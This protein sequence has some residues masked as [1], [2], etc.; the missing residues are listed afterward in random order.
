[1]KKL[2]IVL[3]CVALSIGAFAQNASIHK[4][5]SKKV[6]SKS[7]ISPRVAGHQELVSQPVGGGNRTVLLSE[8]FQGVTLGNAPAAIPTGWTTVA[9]GT[10]TA[11]QTTPAFKIY[12]S[13]LA[14]AGGYWPVPQVGT[15]N[16]FAGANDDPA[17]CDCDFLDVWLQTPSMTL[18]DYEYTSNPVDVYGIITNTAVTDTWTDPQDL[19]SGDVLTATM[20]DPNGTVVW[21]QI[22]INFTVAPAGL[23]VMVNVNGYDFPVTASGSVD[24]SAFG[25]GGDLVWTI[26]A[27]NGEIMSGVTVD[28]TG[29]YE[30]GEIITDTIPAN[31]GDPGAEVV[32]VV[33][34]LDST[35]VGNY[36]LGF[37]FFH[38]ANFGGGD[39]TVQISTDGGAT[40]SVLDTLT[41]DEAYWQSL[42]LPLY[43]YNGMDISIRFQWSD[44]SAWA[45]GFAV[46]NV[47]VQTAL[48]NDIS[49][50]KTIASDW[51]NAT[52]G[53]GFWEYSNVPITQVSPIKATSVVYNAGFNNQLGVGVNYDIDFNG[54]AQGSFASSVLDVV[55]LDKDTLSGVSAFTPSALGTV[56]ITGT[57]AAADLV[58][59]NAN[60]NVSTASIEITQDIYARDLGAAQ[61][62][63]GPTAAYEYGNLFDIYAND[64]FGAIDVCVRL[65]SGV[66]NTTIQGR[67]YE[68]QGLDATTGEPVL[69]DLG[70][71]TQ[72]YTVTD[73]D[74]TSAGGGVWIHLLFDAP[75]TL[76]ADK[77]YFASMVSDGSV[78][79]PVSG[80]NDWVVSWLND[81]TWGATGGI[82]M[83]RLN[84]D[85]T[86]ANSISENK[87]SD[88]TMSQ[89]M[90]NPANAET[91]I[92]Y[93]LPTASPVSVI[94]RD[95]TGRVV[96]NM[97]E[98]V[99]PAGAHSIRINVAE[100]GSGIYTYTLNAGEVH[101]TKEMLVK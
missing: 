8:D 99:K 67:L 20:V 34:V 10:A 45:S 15:N 26:T 50:A 31:Q 88:V 61:A 81:G 55:T 3:G 78:G 94:V 63:V 22:S 9:A 37:D 36:T 92:N 56:T 17:P 23:P 77:I 6:F 53:M 2:Y 7:E 84:S 69:V 39:A 19:G 60:N 75:V 86:L 21:N 65:A 90:P 48:M 57:V 72:E 74:N 18:T 73:V 54:T 35:F 52:F 91:Q 27:S 97:N 96:M 59:D 13:T 68:F 85:E 51:N 76:E 33:D 98:G 44:N 41:I 49:M 25:I 30:T 4:N 12:N 87:A 43:A 11:G 46:D 28:A 14:N 62:F 38:D 82:P 58:D 100:L 40:W 42:V 16:K 47:V 95:V 66:T 29:T 83:I 80:T 71:Q 24:V 1:M 89:N 93:S 32:G 64:D 101:L 5:P 70:V 79:V